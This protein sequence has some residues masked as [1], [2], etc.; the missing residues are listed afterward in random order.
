V[1][2]VAATPLGFLIN[3][4]IDHWIQID[5]AKLSTQARILAAEHKCL[6]YDSYVD[7][8]ELF[9]FDESELTNKRDPVSPAAK[10]DIQAAVTNSK[11]LV[12]KF[13][14]LILKS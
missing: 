3:T 2:C 1:V 4:H 6:D 7:C 12:T 10:A 8:L 14:R 9:P 13:K 11:A 5:P